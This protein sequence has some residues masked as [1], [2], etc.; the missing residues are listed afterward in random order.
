M[1]RILS[2][3]LASAISATTMA[4]EPWYQL[5]DPALVLVSFIGVPIGILAMVAIGLSRRKPPDEI[6][7][8]VAIA[9][10]M[11]LANFAIALILAARMGL[12]YLESLGLSIAVSASNTLLAEK[13]IGKW[14]RTIDDEGELRQQ[15]ARA[16][17]AARQALREERGDAEPTERDLR[18]S[19][20]RERVTGV[21]VEPDPHAEELLRKLDEGDEA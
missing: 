1:W 13:F 18:L 2:P 4:S 17:A 5:A 7:R 3:S 16:M 20:Y 14:S 19:K 15:D 12:P 6:R 10:F 21:P 9:G 8:D 11:A